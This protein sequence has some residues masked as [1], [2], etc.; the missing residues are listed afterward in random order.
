MKTLFLAFIVWIKGEDEA[1]E[2]T[3]RCETSLHYHRR[4]RILAHSKNT[5]KPI[6]VNLKT[7]LQDSF[8]QS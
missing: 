1:P 3:D 4:N 7:E 6:N 2:I 8:Y 5:Y